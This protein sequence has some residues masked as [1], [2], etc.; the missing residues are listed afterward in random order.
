MIGMLAAALILAAAAPPTPNSCAALR[1]HGQVSQAQACYQTL[2]QSDDL[3]LQ[4]EGDW[5]LGQYDAANTAFRAAVARNDGNPL[6]RVRWGR[7]LQERFN[8]TD[9]AALFQEALARDPADADAYLGLALVSADG[10]DGKALEYTHHALTL[11]PHLAEAQTLLATL[12]LEDSDPVAAARAADAALA[13]DPDALDAMAIHASIDVL[14]T[15]N[16]A[17]PSPWLARIAAV[18]PH[19]GRAQEIIADQLVLHRRYEEALAYYRKATELDPQL[20]SAHS[21][22]GI[23]Q[24]RLGQDAAPELELAYN[25]GY[26][27]IATV[28]TLRLLD[29]NKN[30][31]YIHDQTPNGAITLKL[32]KKESALLAPYFER[33][34]ARALAA[35]SAKYGMTLPGPVQIDAYPN[36][37]D[38]AVRSIGLPG[39][40]AL[41]VTFGEVV[42][43]DSPSA[44]PPGDFNWADTLWHELDHV[45]VLTA[46]QHLVPRWFAEGLAVHE[47]TEANPEWGDRITPDV[48]VAISAKK[49]LPV[50]SLDQ[51]FMHPTYPNQVI[52]S[53]YQAG[54]ICDFIEKKLG[55]AKLVEMV[56]DFA[57]PTTT[58]AVINQALSLTPLAF[59]TEFNTWLAQD[60][61]PVPGNFNQWRI[62]LKALAAAAEAKA[63]AGEIIRLGEAVRALYPDYIYDANAYGFLAA[64]YAARNDTAHVISTL[65]DYQDRGGREPALL[66]QLAALEPAPAAAATLERINYIY[67]MV[68]DNHRRLGDLDLQLNRNQEAVLE[69]NSVLALHPLDKA[70]AEYD[71]AR[72]YYANHQLD[73]AK[74]H[75]I[76]SLVAAHD[77][78]PAQDL[79]A[80][81]M[82]K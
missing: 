63:D 75:V 28:N 27:D 54:R 40:G 74:D 48:L 14:A 29:S 15:P 45:Y 76:E 53:Y 81:I 55:A 61:G 2:A 4:A 66:L 47:E 51:G 77:F 80:E 46:T 41:G 3:Y 64:A 37:D 6:Y 59:D 70:G 22:L 20:W 39:L 73:Q 62:Q 25:N 57:Q 12:E 9:A 21:A 19:Y 17:V 43:M 50:A 24:M 42:A 56:H 44:R 13:S 5:G 36:H 65:T 16:T 33:I 58:S 18:N 71:L 34:T 72:A 79:L 11:N 38:F 8:D 67:P 26:R 30:F 68:A 1:L 52:V 82:K 35:Y 60:L 32:D 7:L 31:D 10:F 49:L 23:D 78:R 69:F